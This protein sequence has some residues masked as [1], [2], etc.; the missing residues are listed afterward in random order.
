MTEFDELVGRIRCCTL[1]TLS[2]KRT[3]AVPGEGAR[4]AT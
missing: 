1:C 3:Q 2:Q 4:N